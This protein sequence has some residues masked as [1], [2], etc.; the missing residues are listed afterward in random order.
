MTS[1]ARSQ[2]LIFLEPVRELEERMVEDTV[3][4][5]LDYPIMHPEPTEDQ[6][7]SS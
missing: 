2:Y 4:K 3:S 1:Q 6:A 5:P 7:L